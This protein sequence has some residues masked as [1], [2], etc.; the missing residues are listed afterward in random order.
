MNSI[1]ATA[2]G[3]TVFAGAKAVDVYRATALS[4]GLRLYAKSGMLPNRAWTPRLMMNAA[5]QITGTKFKARD[6]EG[7]ATALKAWADATA[8][9]IK[10]EQS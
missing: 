8:A 10:K 9:Q 5:T 6:Y 7:A 3:G 1:T 2:A 4:H